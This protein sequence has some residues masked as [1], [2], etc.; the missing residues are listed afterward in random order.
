[1]KQNAP[2]GILNARRSFIG[3]REPGFDGTS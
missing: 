1:V 3:L 2:L